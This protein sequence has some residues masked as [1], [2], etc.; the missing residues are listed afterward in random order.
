MLFMAEYDWFNQYLPN[1]IPESNPY[2]TYPGKDR[3]IDYEMKCKEEWKKRAS[4]IFLRYFP[5][6]YAI[7][8]LL[9]SF[10]I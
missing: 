8:L 10:I 9:I 6:V 2:E 5:K 7:P 1:A 3:T 4:A